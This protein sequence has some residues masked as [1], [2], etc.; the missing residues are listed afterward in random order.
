MEH[1]PPLS[2]ASATASPVRYTLL[3]RTFHRT[4]AVL[5]AGMFVS[6]LESQ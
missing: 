3:A 1:D 5:I 2:F 6:M 4:I